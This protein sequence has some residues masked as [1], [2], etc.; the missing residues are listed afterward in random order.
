MV[1]L[2]GHSVEESLL[3]DAPIVLDV[4]ARGFDFTT[5][6]LN[7]RPHA[8]IIAM[9]PDPSVGDPNI[10][11]VKFL[12]VALVHDDR[13]DSGYASWSTGE[14]NILTER[15]PTYANSFCRV[16]CINIT[17][18]MRDVGIRHFDL[19]KLDCEG[20]EFGIL[21]NWPGP[22]ATQISVEFHDW[23][24]RIAYSDEFFRELFLALPWYDVVSHPCFAID[25]QHAVGHWD[26][27]LVRK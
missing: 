10:S 6:V 11:N 25:G 8:S 20:S 15:P 4:G 24:D 17:R 9:E 13:S 3:P 21:R 7:I 14:G 19:V 1:M 2:S 18:L 16:P 22:I 26:S 23:V 5:A 27:L 12:Q